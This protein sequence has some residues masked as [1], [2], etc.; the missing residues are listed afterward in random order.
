MINKL[1]RYRI[2]ILT[3]VSVV[4]LTT[5]LFATYTIYQRLKA[6]NINGYGNLIVEQC[7]HIGPWDYDYRCSGTWQQ[8][9]GMLSQQ[10]AF[11][12]VVGRYQKGDVIQDVYPSG[13]L[14][15]TGSG[16]LTKQFVTGATRRSLL[17]NL[18]LV[19]LIIFAL[20]CLAWIVIISVPHATRRRRYDI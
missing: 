4:M 15:A 2:L 14:Y 10:D 5:A 11:V 6:D 3:T 19:L 16:E 18:P 7:H 20:G 12:D 1:I 13:P 8:G 17:Y 9:S